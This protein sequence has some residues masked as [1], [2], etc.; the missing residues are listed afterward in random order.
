[1]KFLTVLTP[2]ERTAAPRVTPGSLTLMEDAVQAARENPGILPAS[3]D[4]AEYVNEVQLQRPSEQLQ[5]ASTRGEGLRNNPI[6]LEI[7][8][9]A[10]E[11][12][13][14]PAERR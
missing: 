1:M 10:V 8:P 4:L 6:G 5:R 7:L 2:K 12:P 13:T 9:S 11:I 3:M 14:W